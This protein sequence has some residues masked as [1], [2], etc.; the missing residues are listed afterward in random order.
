MSYPQE[1]LV[2]LYL[3]D[4]VLIDRNRLCVLKRGQTKALQPRALEVLLLLLE[5][6]WRVVEKKELF[7]R[8]WKQAYVSDGALTQ[9]IKN[10]RR[11]IGDRAKSS[12]YISTVPK[13]GYRFIA[14]VTEIGQNNTSEGLRNS[15]IAVLPFRNLSGDPH[16][17]FF[18]HGLSEELIT[19]LTKVEELQVVAATLAHDGNNSFHQR[20]QTASVVHGSVQKS[21][22]QWRIFV[23]LIR[24]SDGHYLWTELYDRGSEDEFAIHDEVAGAIT[25]SLQKILFAQAGNSGRFEISDLQSRN[26]FLERAHLYSSKDLGSSLLLE[27]NLNSS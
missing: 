19:Q 16:N 12:L 1:S 5:N 23:Q 11:A 7:E 6:R 8:I 20:F 18:C 21:G 24:T 25:D 15:T 14:D 4:D 2:S 3:F 27:Q 9:E 26:S 17:D 10:I 22:N 13:H